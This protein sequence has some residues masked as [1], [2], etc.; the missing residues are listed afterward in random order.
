MKKPTRNVIPHI[1]AVLIFILI[2]SFYFPSMFQGKEISQSDMTGYKGM[3]KEITD[4]REET[5][6][7][8]L[9]TNSMFSGM[10]AYLINMKTP[11]N[12]FGKINQIFSF[13]NGR[14]VIHI[15]LYMFGFYILLL[16][17]GI[18]PWLGIVGGIAYGFSS[19][20]FIILEP[21]HITKAIALGYMPMIIGGI[22]Y[23]FRKDLIVGAI[24][25]S[26]FL[27]LQ[28]VVNH[29]QITYYTLL[30]ILIFGIFE[31]VEV[32][33][34]KDF[35]KFSKTIG[36]LIIAVIL[37]VSVN[38]VNLWS[39][40]DYS[41]Y[42]LRGPSELTD[43]SDDKTSGLDKSYATGWS[44]GIGETLNLLIP[45]FKGGASGI[46][47]AD[48][49][50]ETFKFLSRSSNPQQ[51]VQIINQ[52]AYFF[53]QYWGNQ[54][55]TSGPV[56]IGAVIVFL[57]VFG[58]FFLKGKIRW[59]L[60]TVVVFSILLSWG[61][62]FMFLSDFFLEYFPGYNKF[63][64]VS[65]I[66]VM[67]EFAM[68]LL[69]ILAVNKLL[70]EEFNKKEFLD[71]FKYTIIIVGGITLFFAL[72]PTMSDLS[73]QK[74]KLLIDQG[75]G[76]LVNAIKKDRAD[77][78]RADA[79]RSLIFVLLAAGL[80]YTVFLKKIKAGYFYL[81]LGLIILI[82]LW[83]VNKRYV[84][85]ENF[86][87]KSVARVPYHPNAADLEILKD[88]ELY[89]RVFDMT[90][91]DP[92][93][94][95]RTS[96]FH[97]SIGGY[98]G[99]KM[100]RYQEVFDHHIKTE[101]D[102]DILNMLNTKYLIQRDPNSG[103]AVAMQRPGNLGNAWFV[104][105][106]ELVEDADEEINKIGELNTKITASIDKRFEEYIENQNFVRDSSSSIDLVEYAPNKLKYRYSSNSSQIAVFS[107][108]YY[109]K[110]WVASI[111]GVEVSYFRANYIL[112]AMVVPQGSGTISFEFRPKSYF[113]G[114]K[115]SSAASVLIIL[116]ILGIVMKELGII[117]MKFSK[118]E[119]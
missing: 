21:G 5:G 24:L 58:M 60:F 103:Q 19:Y 112:R 92:F 95:S 85:E 74:D 42:S 111:D 100:R 77:L 63:R 99:A 105:D 70:F 82:D 65:M 26:I 119:D 41:E 69:A 25:T 94:S 39:V 62:N 67:A 87:T 8:A 31:L 51:A 33:K 64:T 2:P 52:N 13:Q 4:Y 98:H 86:V 101:F 9:W 91:G 53:T 16:L 20:F 47:M 93:A 30:I 81:A 88:K 57:F 37:S 7:E 104:S 106:Y 71:S 15:F 6:E 32:I 110:G 55:G 109:P 49:D 78:L 29:L 3:A 22:Y 83:P 108:I 45:N 102:E 14:P 28:I 118:K 117:K 1:I 46:L 59:W 54:P 114:S 38:I 11:F 84:N 12:V 116:L 113:T 48:N 90:Q 43:S 50:S 66:L 68:P 73:S 44:Y 27:G 10:P 76:D 97:S 89:Y 23:S 72:F 34:N 35:S 17:F 115:I 18:N 40:S 61:K 36:A 75:A 107:D 79:F 80:L 96:Y 56:Y